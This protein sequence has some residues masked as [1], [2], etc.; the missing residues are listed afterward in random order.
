[1]EEKKRLV[2]LLTTK[3]KYQYQITYTI[4]YWSF[5]LA[6]RHREHCRPR[7]G[8]PRPPPRW[9]CGSCAAAGFRW[10]LLTP[11]AVSRRHSGR[12]QRRRPSIDSLCR[13]LSWLAEDV[14][15]LVVHQNWWPRTSWSTPPWVLLVW[16]LQLK[17]QSVYFWNQ[18]YNKSSRAR[19]A[20]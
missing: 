10:P 20:I 1:V 7:C 5:S 11:P 6:Q 3:N 4:T 8:C 2:L 14:A 13:C 16:N 17:N 15:A 19:V 9:S 12:W 18:G